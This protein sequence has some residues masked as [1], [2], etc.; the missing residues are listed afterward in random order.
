MSYH[1]RNEY[2]APCSDGCDVFVH[3]HL[4]FLLGHLQH[5]EDGDEGACTTHTITGDM[6][7]G[8]EGK[9]QLC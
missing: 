5:G 8:R 9:E 4:P 6:E 2:W 1:V 3:V 7:G